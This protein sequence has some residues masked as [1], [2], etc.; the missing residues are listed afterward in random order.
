MKTRLLLLILALCS[1]SCQDNA[2]LPS[3]ELIQTRAVVDK[4]NISISNP[5][6]ITNW[7][8]L[9]EITLNTIG[10]S[11]INKRVSTP[12]TD[13]STPLSEKFRKEKFVMIL[14]QRTGGLCC[15]TPLKKWD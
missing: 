5:E 13:S 1:A 3:Q 4:N 2:F 14:R 6:L 9:K 11:T 15:F 10:T 12:W 7:E 8:N